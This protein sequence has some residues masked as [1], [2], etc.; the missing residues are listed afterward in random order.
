MLIGTLIGSNQQLDDI[1]LHFDSLDCTIALANTGE[2]AIVALEYSCWLEA[3]LQDDQTLQLELQLPHETSRISALRSQQVTKKHWVTKGIAITRKKQPGVSITLTAEEL[4]DHTDLR[5]GVRYAVA[6]G[7]HFDL[8]VPSSLAAIRILEKHTPQDEIIN[9]DQVRVWLL[10]NPDTQQVTTTR[11]A[12]ENQASGS[13][14]MDQMPQIKSSLL[15]QTTYTRLFWE[16]SAPTVNDPFKL[17]VIARPVTEETQ[18]LSEITASLKQMNK[19]MTRVEN[20][21][22]DFEARLQTIQLTLDA[23][24]EDSNSLDDDFAL[25]TRKPAAKK[26]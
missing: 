11:D 8:S 10:Y 3:P 14:F 24:A 16:G 2:K 26:K 4:A 5:F 21:L 18:A 6:V 13:N 7:T 1:G 17:A 15:S 22:T 12:A 19:R 23:L 20:I 25:P 9:V